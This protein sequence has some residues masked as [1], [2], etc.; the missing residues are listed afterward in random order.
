LI[1]L[2]YGL[3]RIDPQRRFVHDRILGTQVIAVAPPVKKKG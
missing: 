2:A 1:A 3:A